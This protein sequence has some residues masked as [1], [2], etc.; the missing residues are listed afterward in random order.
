MFWF[1]EVGCCRLFP[2][3]NGAL[4]NRDFDSVWQ[5]LTTQFVE[6]GY[7]IKADTIEELAKGLN[8]PAENLTAAV[9]RYNEL[10]ANGVDEDYGKEAYRLRPVAQAPFYGFFMGGSLLTTCDGLQIN[11]KCQVYDTEHKVIDGLYCIGD[12]SGSFFSGNYPEYIVGVAC[13]RSS[14]EGRHVAKLLAGAAE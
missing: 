9:K 4:S 5:Q 13:G 11:L 10:C 6:E 8:I 12:C 3:D 2:F 14:V 7:V 1:G